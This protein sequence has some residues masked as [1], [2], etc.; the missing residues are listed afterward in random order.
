MRSGGVLL[1]WFLSELSGQV[2]CPGGDPASARAGELG[3]TFVRH[4]RQTPVNHKPWD[5]W[6]L[7]SAGGGPSMIAFMYGI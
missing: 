3:M 7:V 4:P 5:R 1:S 6:L 2:H